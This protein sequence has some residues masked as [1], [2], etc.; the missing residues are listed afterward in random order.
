MIGLAVA[1]ASFSGV[2]CKAAGGSGGK[3]EGTSWALETYDV[4]GVATAVPAGVSVDA[5]FTG[6]RISGFGG[7]N[8][9]S[10]DASVSG[11]S[12]T[13]G[14]L[15]ATQMACIGEAGSVETA[16]FAKLGMAASFTATTESLTIFDRAGK[17]VLVY[18]IGASNPLAR[19][20]NVTGINNGNQAVVSP[21]LGT[22]VTATF[23]ADGKLTGSAGCNAYTG[24]YTLTGR[25]VAIG[26]LAST[27]RSCEATVMTQEAQFLA[28]MGK[29]T[30]FDSSGP[31]IMLRDASGAMQVVLS[32]PAPAGAE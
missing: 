15:A 6:N 22:T 5:R 32:H 21:Q 9:F 14:P 27:R 12:L 3:L 26:P 31:T 30:S 29:V 28:A 25:D 8:S 16:Y 19:A 23:T 10:G 1:A 17:P 20:W 18:R 2:D 7:C 4:S 11:A 13:L 24:S